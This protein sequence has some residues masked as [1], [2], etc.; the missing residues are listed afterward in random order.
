MTVEGSSHIAA[1]V[2][3]KPERRPNLTFIHRKIPWFSRS[4]EVPSTDSLNG[5][6]IVLRIQSSI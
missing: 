2:S 5:G 3:N 4:K 6:L 1:I